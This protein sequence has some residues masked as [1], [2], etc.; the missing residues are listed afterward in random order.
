MKIVAVITFCIEHRKEN[1]IF[2]IFK[3]LFSF[4]KVWFYRK[5]LLNLFVYLNFYFIM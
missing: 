4:K 1:K 2:F 3:T 5:V